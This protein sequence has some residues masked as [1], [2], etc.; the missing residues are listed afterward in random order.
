M[1][2]QS[3]VGHPGATLERAAVLLR[4]GQSAALTRAGRAQTGSTKLPGARIAQATDEWP[5]SSPK[6]TKAPERRIAAT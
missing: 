4:E 5:L 3:A 6:L 2:M 1:G